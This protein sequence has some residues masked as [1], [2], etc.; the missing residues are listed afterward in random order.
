MAQPDQITLLKKTIFK[1]AIIGISQN[2]S[3][4]HKHS[5]SI[6]M[7]ANAC[8]DEYDAQ[9]LKQMIHSLNSLA[10]LNLNDTEM[11]LID[12]VVLISGSDGEN[13]R[14]FVRQ[15][16]N[17]LAAQLSRF[18][19]PED[20]MQRVFAILDQL[21]QLDHLHKDCLKRFKSSLPNPASLGL[22]ELYSE[23]FSPEN[24]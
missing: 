10:S 15:L 3:G 12:A 1:L 8:K 18:S 19:G 7:L 16:R 4:T 21:K 11:A 22:P 17:C 6:T 13:E 14:R 23:L 24:N 20:V 5:D 9:F 2:I